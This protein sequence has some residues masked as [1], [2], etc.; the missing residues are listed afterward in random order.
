LPQTTKENA[1][2]AWFLYD[3]EYNK[4]E[5]RNHL[6]LVDTVYTEF[7]AALQQVI[8]TKPGQMSDFLTLL[9]GKLD[10]RISNEPD[11]HSAFELL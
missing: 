7:H 5:K 2:I 10:E 9:Q 3:L 8:Y 4:Q 11:P 1:D 6:V